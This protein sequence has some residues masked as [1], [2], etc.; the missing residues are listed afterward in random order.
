MMRSCWLGPQLTLDALGFRID[1]SMRSHESLTKLINQSGYPLQLAVDEL[2]TAGTSGWKV[3]RRESGWRAADGKSGFIDL[4]LENDW[5]SS[6]LVVECK[7]VLESDWLF[8]CD[9][10]KRK[11]RRTARIWI[12]N[13][14][15]HGVEYFGY[16]DAVC[17]PESFVSMFCVVPGQ[18]AKARPMLERVAVDV[19]ASTEALASEE[20]ALMD[21]RQYGIRMYGSV[22]VT[23]A[24]L[25][26]S[27]LDPAAVNLSTGEVPSAHHEEIPW[28]RFRKPFSSDP[29]IMPANAEW[30]FASLA[31]AKDKLVFVVNVLHLDTFL[32]TWS[33]SD[34]SL[35]SLM[36]SR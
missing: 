13:T 34:D 29:V 20:R 11:P 36:S 18:D 5:G 7:R 12:T 10:R 23:T 15:G 31:T 22:I 4:A 26:L 28:I 21:R 19:L 9:A 2:V 35:R 8:L 24:K 30:E 27:S 3:Y 1:I 14:A 32:R 16:F 6:V 33:V 25:Q 17:N